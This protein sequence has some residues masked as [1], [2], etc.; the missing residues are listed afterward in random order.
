MGQSKAGNERLGEGVISTSLSFAPWRA[1]LGTLLFRVPHL[2]ASETADF[3]VGW[4]GGSGD[5]GSA[6]CDIVGDALFDGDGGG[7]VRHG[8][9]LEGIILLLG[10]RV[11]AVLVAVS[12]AQSGITEMWDAARGSEPDVWR[13]VKAGLS[14]D[15]V[16]EEAKA[17]KLVRLDGVLGE[18]VEDVVFVTEKTPHEVSILHVGEYAHG[19]F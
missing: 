12:G 18:F 2:A 4:N 13:G 9:I 16:E 3:G 11:G 5:E 19:F 1:V 14:D 6:A 15:A 10:E 7:A 8:F 17:E